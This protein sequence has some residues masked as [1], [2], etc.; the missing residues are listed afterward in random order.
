MKELLVI[1]A[2]I[3]GLTLAERFSDR[4]VLVLE[5]GDAAGGSIKTL[6]KDGYQL[7]LGANSLLLRDTGRDLLKRLGLRAAVVPK[8]GMRRYL[9]LPVRG[10]E[11]L[12]EVP[13]NPLSFFS[14]PILSAA[15]K[16]RIFREPFSPRPL[17]E[18]R[19]VEEFIS[20]RLGPEV[21]SRMI[22]PL[23]SG[24]YA[25]DI[26]R[27]SARTALG[28]LH[29][30][31][32]EH[33]SILLGALR[34]KKVPGKKRGRMEMA[35]FPGGLSDLINTLA[36]RLGD[37]LK[38]NSP[39]QSVDL[40]KRPYR[41]TGSFGEIKTNRLVITTDALTTANLLGGE[42]KEPLSALPYSPVGLLYLAVDTAVD[43]SGVGFLC[44]PKAG[45]ALLGALYTSTSFP[46]T[47]PANRQL[48]TCFVGGAL[49]PDLADATDPEIQGQVIRE[50]RSLLPC[51]PE[52]IHS[53]FWPR[54]IPSFPVGHYKLV[55][56][57]RE[58]EKRHPGVTF[59]TNWLEKPGVAD[60]IERAESYQW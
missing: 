33:G 10:E 12:V 9:A 40:S 44:Q 38:L 50:L 13:L 5:Q 30:F 4:E 6:K 42:L 17:K 36:G 7:E 59:L 49:N 55:T 21:S 54:A 47:A 48:L 43:L 11:R 28:A 23:F 16:F 14:S 19:S 24:I 18:D 25:S 32:Q 51:R 20:D 15:A 26:S 41:V 60:C 56:Q 27:L 35:N 45:R 46:H 3:S 31:E 2:G 57:V 39:V 53:T 37:K 29:Q 58:F 1:G 34:R 22:A 52:L 8:S